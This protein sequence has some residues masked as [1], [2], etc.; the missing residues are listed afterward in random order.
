MRRP[1]PISGDSSLLGRLRALGM[2]AWKDVDTRNGW[3]N[4]P[5]SHVLSLAG[6]KRCVTATD[7]GRGRPSHIADVPATADHE[8]R[9]A[10]SYPSFH[11]SIL[12]FCLLPP[13]PLAIARRS[14]NSLG[15]R[16]P[17]IAPRFFLRAEW[18]NF[19]SAI[20]RLA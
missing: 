2:E 17:A 10:S 8:F 6:S 13:F 4:L 20:H 16:L 5:A 18:Q 11:P 19:D 7:D 1:D 3:A 9:F 15:K 12:P 14:P